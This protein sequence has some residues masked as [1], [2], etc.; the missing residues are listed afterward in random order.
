MARRQGNSSPDAVARRH[1]HGDAGFSMLE[2]IVA[3]GI[4]G[5]CLIPILNLQISVNSGTGRLQGVVD[6]LEAKRVAEGYLRAAAVPALDQGAIRFADFD[7]EWQTTRRSDSRAAMS[8]QSA[9]GRFD[10]T[11][12]RIEYTITAGPAQSRGYVDRLVWSETSAYFP[13]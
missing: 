2:A 8:D 9:P 3:I 12:V 7:L 1:D 10:V 13:E 6:T 5:I 4:L 11:L